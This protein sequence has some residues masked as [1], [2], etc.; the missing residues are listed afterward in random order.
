MGLEH[1]RPDFSC[2][3]M[4]LAAA[5]PGK[6]DL[7]LNKLP[8]GISQCLTASSPG[9][10]DGFCLQLYLFGLHAVKLGRHSALQA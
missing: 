7:W 9:G 8:A 6:Y 4:T 2:A 5:L 3:S 1:S 10:K